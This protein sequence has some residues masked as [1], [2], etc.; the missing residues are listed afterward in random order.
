[1]DVRQGKAVA[2]R[3]S[4]RARAKANQDNNLMVAKAAKPVKKAKHGEMARVNAHDR[5]R[6]DSHIVENTING[7]QV[8]KHPGE[9][10]REVT[11]K[12]QRPGLI[13]TKI[14]NTTC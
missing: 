7:S 12:G 8:T 4:L 3:P 6:S 5:H 13:R 9:G 14:V 1:M 10:T 11:L 2:R